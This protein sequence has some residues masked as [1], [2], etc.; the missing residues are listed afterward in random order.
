[1]TYTVEV[2]K[3]F[4]LALLLSLLLVAALAPESFGR[5][6]QKI[7]TGR[8]EFVDCDCS[9]AIEDAVLDVMEQDP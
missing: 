9:E 3:T 4:I 6:L 7:D 1:M 5:W 2:L 8:V